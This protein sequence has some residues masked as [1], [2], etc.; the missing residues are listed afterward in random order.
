MRPLPRL[1]QA[2]LLLPTALLLLAADKSSSSLAKKADPSGTGPLM[3]QL[4]ALFN[5]WDVN[6]DGFLDKAEL[7]RG[8]RGED[9]K[10]YEPKAGKDAKNLKDLG[11]FPD[12]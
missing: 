9:A 6:K 3:G 5:T 2:A 7:A 11:D 10:A 4:R 8:F 1:L 12:Y